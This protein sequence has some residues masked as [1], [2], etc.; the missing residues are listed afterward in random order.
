MSLVAD[1]FPDARGEAMG[2]A[3]AGGGAGAFL[4]PFATAFV[5]KKFGIRIG[6]AIFIPLA[7]GVLAVS[8]FLARVT[9]KY[10]R[11]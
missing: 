1:A 11:E 8:A 5:G 10:A 4:L 2:F 7:F 9:G 3:A 6:Y